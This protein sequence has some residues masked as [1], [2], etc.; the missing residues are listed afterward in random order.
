MNKYKVI[1][2]NYK[3]ELLFW[4]AGVFLFV[5][6]IFFVIYK[7]KTLYEIKK[8]Y[9]IAL[10]TKRKFIIALNEIKALDIEMPKISKFQE[11]KVE[12]VVDLNNIF[13]L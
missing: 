10:S 9:E 1:I 13:L 11:T 2:K 8:T 4:F 7:I 3:K 5:F 12:G 6:S